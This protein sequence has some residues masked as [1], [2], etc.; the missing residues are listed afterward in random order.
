MKFSPQIRKGEE[1]HLVEERRVAK[2][3]QV[4]LR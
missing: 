3:V 4:P 2:Y 1:A